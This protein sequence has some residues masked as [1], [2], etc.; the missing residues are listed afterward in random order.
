MLKTLLLA[1]ASAL[2]MSATSVEAVTFT[3]AGALQSYHVTKAG[4]Y[5]IDA[6]GAQGGGGV[7]PPY[8]NGGAKIGG[9]IYLAA[10]TT[11][12]VLVGGKGQWYGNTGGSGGG[13]SAVFT[14]A[15]V[16]LVV[17]GGGGGSDWMGYGGGPGLAGPAYGSHGGSG[18]SGGGG[19]SGGGGGGW[20]SPGTGGGSNYA[21]GGGYGPPS[22]KGG[23]GGNSFPIPIGPGDFGAS[24]GFGGGGGGGYDGGGGGGGYAGGDAGGGGGSYLVARATH[25][26]G[27][28]GIQ[29]GNGL[30]TIDLMGSGVPEPSAWGLMLTGLGFLGYVLRRRLMARL[31]RA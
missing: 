22:F 10:G 7:G 27:E 8:S 21:G 11:L 25:T 29:A 20:R 24:G 1:G 31:R 3:Y 15:L 17:A 5:Q 6:F 30:V 12:E 14:P 9:D 26:V 28:S 4:D 16:P 19:Y 2:A 13:M 18:G 23:F